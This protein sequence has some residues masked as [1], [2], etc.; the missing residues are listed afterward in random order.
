MLHQLGQ[1]DEAQKSY[2]NALKIDPEYLH[3]NLALALN[4]EKQNNQWR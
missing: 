1:L 2:K 3:A 4:F